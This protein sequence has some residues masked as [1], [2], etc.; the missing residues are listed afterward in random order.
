MCLTI[1]DSFRM[2]TRT[3]IFFLAFLTG[4]FNSSCD[5]NINHGL[6]AQSNTIL[7]I[8][9]D[10]FTVNG[11]PTFLLGVSYFDGRNYHES[12]LV[13]FGAKGFNLVRVWLDW[14]TNHYFDEDGN[15]LSGA[16]QDLV[17]LVD[18]ANAQGLV[19]DVTILDDNA[20]F[21]V[22]E[23]KRNRAVQNVTTLLKDKPNVLFDVANEHDHPGFVTPVDH[24]VAAQLVTVVK[25]IDPDRIC[26]ISSTGC[27][28]ICGSDVSNIE[29]NNVKEEID[30]VNVDVLTPHFLR[31]TDWADKLAPRLSAVK[32][33]LRS[34]NKNIPVYLQE[35]NRR[36]DNN[37]PTKEEFFRSAQS[38]VKEGAAAWIF[39]TA[40]GFSM[41]NSTF[42]DNLDSTEQQV[43]DELANLIFGSTADVI[44]PASPQNIQVDL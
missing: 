4:F 36:A 9:G 24:S 20:P 1:H 40:A 10:R 37:G 26:T 29:K 16:D 34:I 11:N 25:Q 42:F 43:V 7:G 21:A 33:H 44:P 38:A 18:F 8:A 12:D 27:H 30:Q 19:V 23:S 22:S 3:L 35:E 32:E 6:F 5:F 41:Q 39:H 2:K 13:S 31:G 14:R 17:R 15:W 28:V